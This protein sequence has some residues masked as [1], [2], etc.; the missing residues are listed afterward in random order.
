MQFQKINEKDPEKIYMTRYNNLA[1][2][3]I[4]GEVI[5]FVET[6]TAGATG[7]E[8]RTLTAAVN[9]T[10]GVAADLAGVTTAAVAATT[11]FTAQVYGPANVRTETT[12]TAG[13]LAVASSVSTT[14]KAALDIQTTTTTAAYAQAALGMSLAVTNATNATIQ[15]RVL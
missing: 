3:L 6:A 15:L 8:I 11:R 14:S 13:R 9:A 7:L 12:L 1:A 2:T 10:T 5:E 4:A